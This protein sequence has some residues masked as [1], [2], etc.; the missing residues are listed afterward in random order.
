MKKIIF[1]T[2]IFVALLLVT[3]SSKAACVNLTECQ[4]MYS[5]RVTN[6]MNEVNV[7]TGNTIPSLDNINIVTQDDL[8]ADWQVYNNNVLQPLL[9]AIEASASEAELIDLINNTDTAT[10]HLALVQSTFYYSD[11]DQLVSNIQDSYILINETF[12]YVIQHTRASSYNNL[13]AKYSLISK[14][15]AKS[16]SSAADK[17]GSK[18]VCGDGVVDPNEE[19]DNPKDEWCTVDCKY[20]YLDDTPQI[21]SSVDNSVGV[22]QTE[23]TALDTYVMEI[24]SELS[25]VS[26]LDLSSNSALSALDTHRTNLETIQTNLNN[27]ILQI[28]GNVENLISF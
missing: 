15:Y 16:S 27:T 7:A 23:Q 1:L 6:K 25:R 17:G 12:D 10:M 22:I 26:Q 28:T 5:E 8:I 19:C 18:Y 2:L 3:G 20:I 9:T 14:A 24:D 13:L 4:A 21:K 11:A